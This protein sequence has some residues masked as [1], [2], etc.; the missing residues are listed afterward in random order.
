M[1]K[2]KTKR[3]FDISITLITF[4]IGI[5]LI[6]Y[7]F[8]YKKVIYDVPTQI[9][10]ILAAFGLLL[11]IL[12]FRINYLRQ[13]NDYI[14][15][16][17]FEEYLRIR[18]LFSDFAE[19][20]NNH[21]TLKFNSHVLVNSLM[22][23]K[24]ELSQLININDKFL[25]PGIINK[26]SSKKIAKIINDIL[27]RT[28]KFRKQIDDSLKDKKLETDFR[29]FLNITQQVGWHNEIRG[30]LKEFHKYKYKFFND[31]REYII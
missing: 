12:Q 4:G 13:R 27:L 17:R 9:A 8:V 3:W 23:I 15:K 19:N 1:E 16:I 29:K 22:N 26:K 5:I 2:I 7:F 30:K 28:D 14:N 21:M 18:K 25:F 11:G 31:L 10:T 20:I 24:N 6:W